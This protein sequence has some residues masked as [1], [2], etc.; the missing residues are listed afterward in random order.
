MEVPEWWSAPSLFGLW[1]QPEKLPDFVVG[2]RMPGETDRNMTIGF[3][4]AVAEDPAI[5]RFRP[6]EKLQY[7]AHMVNVT[8][9]AAEI[10]IAHADSDVEVYSGNAESVLE[11]AVTV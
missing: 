10:R 8:D 5:R 6:G 1:V 7:D 4:P 11:G 3:R 2:P 9:A